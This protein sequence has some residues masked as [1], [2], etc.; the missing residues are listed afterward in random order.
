MAITGHGIACLPP[1][2][3]RQEILDGRLV[4]LLEQH[5]HAVD[6]FSVLWPASRQVAAR[7]RAFID[8]MT[9]RLTPE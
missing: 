7:L 8:F 1:F 5:V 9:S 3:V 6:Q 2:A 4:S